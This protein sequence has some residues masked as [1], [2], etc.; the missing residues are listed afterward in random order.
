MRVLLDECVDWRLLRD[1]GEAASL[2]L[3]VVVLRGRTTRLMDLREILPALHDALKA[4]RIGEFK[5][6]SWRDRR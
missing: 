2:Q 4:P 6:L 3:A 1:L 5:I